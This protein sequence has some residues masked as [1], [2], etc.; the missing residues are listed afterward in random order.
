MCEL[1]PENPEFFL[2]R[3]RDEMNYEEAVKEILKLP[4]VGPKVADCV[5]LMSLG[6]HEAIPVDTHIKKIWST[7]YM[8]S[9]ESVPKTLT[10][11]KYNEIAQYFRN[12]HGPFAGWAQSV[13]FSMELKQFQQFKKK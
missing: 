6:K 5:C 2:K 8:A 11:S 3:L 12:L 7:S 4:G 13:L 9:G 10:T 1:F